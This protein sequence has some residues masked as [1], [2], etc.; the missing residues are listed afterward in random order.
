MIVPPTGGARETDLVFQR[1]ERLVHPYPDAVPAP[2]PKTF[3]AFLWACAAG[4][5]PYLFWVT[6]FT[7]GIGAFEALL[8]SMMAHVVDVLAKVQPGELWAHEGTT[9]LLLSGVLLG[10]IALAGSLSMAYVR[11]WRFWARTAAPPRLHRSTYLR[12]PKR[13]LSA[14]GERVTFL[15]S[16]TSTSPMIATRRART[17]LTCQATRSS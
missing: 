16:A 17:V 2:P 5:R 13:M 14:N 8:F 4:V 9:L 3:F 6:V 12:R 7:A 11:S 1:F 15:L 10:S